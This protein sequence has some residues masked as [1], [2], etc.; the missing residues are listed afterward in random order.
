MSTNEDGQSTVP[1]EKNQIRAETG[2][3]PGT[4]TTMKIDLL[5]EIQKMRT[6]LIAATE[7]IKKHQ[8]HSL[9]EL[10]SK[11]E[12][13]KKEN[14]KNLDEISEKLQSIE[15]SEKSDNT[16]SFFPISEKIFKLKHVFKTVNEFQEN[17]FNVGGEEDH[18]NVKWCISAKRSNGHL[19]LFVRCEP[20]APADKWSIRTK[21]ECKIVGIKQHYITRAWETC[22]RTSGGLG[23]HKFIDWESMKRWYLLNGDLTVEVNA[24]IVEEAGLR[25]K[26]I[27]K[28]DG[29]QKDVSDVILVVR[30][31]KFYVLKTFLASQSSVFKALLF[32]KFSESEQSEVTLNGIDPH[33][34]HYFLEV[35]YGES[36]IDESNIENIVVLADMYD[37]PT[38][39]RRCE[40]FLLKESKK[41]LEKKLEIATRHHLEDLKKKCMNE[42]TTTV[43]QKKAKV[44][45]KNPLRKLLCLS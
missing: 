10:E 4:D 20:I 15:N 5:G 1:L 35:L 2:A 32:G 21:F 45:K 24:E 13:V 16:T 7:E 41:A 28:F 38:A 22:Y 17:V 18:Y 26:K 12:D 34:F 37:A 3:I 44:T 14:K 43:V 9:Q 6:E 40:E 27:R 23:F 39:M 33:D 30:D 8:K 29:S 11:I 31:T 25:K 42:I 19:G 36:A